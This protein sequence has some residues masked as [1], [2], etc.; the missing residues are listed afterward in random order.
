MY[1][2]TSSA[3]NSLPLYCQ[4]HAQPPPHPTPP[5]TQTQGFQPEAN[6]CS[7]VAHRDDETPRDVLSTPF[8]FNQ[9][10]N[11]LES[12]HDEVRTL[13]KQYDELQALV[14]EKIGKGKVRKGKAI[15]NGGSGKHG[16]S[17]I[18]TTGD[19]PGPSCV[20]QTTTSLVDIEVEPQVANMENTDRHSRLKPSDGIIAEVAQ[21]SE[22]EAKQA[23]TVRAISTYLV[24]FLTT[25]CRS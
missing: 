11:A 6:R 22:E 10:N 15:E 17:Q 21:L 5:F 4:V 3:C 18:A 23:L 7:E 24:D 25:R 19:E 8:S 14:A 9:L 12:A 2:D 16:A 13:R 1:V 20:Q